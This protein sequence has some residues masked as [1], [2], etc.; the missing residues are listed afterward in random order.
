MIFFSIYIIFEAPYTF[1]LHFLYITKVCILY[2]KRKILVLHSFEF[3]MPSF[4]CFGT[5]SDEDLKAI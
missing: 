4:L 1:S 3:E 2:M 5:G